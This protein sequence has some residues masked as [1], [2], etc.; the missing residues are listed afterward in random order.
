MTGTLLWVQESRPPAPSITSNEALPSVTASPSA[1]A[2]VMPVPDQLAAAQAALTRGN[3]YYDAQQWGQAIEQYKLV[4]ASGGDDPNVRTDLGNALRFNGQAQLA[5]QQYQIAQNQDPSHEQ[6][7]FNQGG[8]WTFAL[9]NPKKGVEA[10]RTYLK[11]FPNGH[12][13][14]DA[15]AFIKQ[16]ERK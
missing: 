7:L 2:P 4:I 10:W 16:H 14:K 9:H 12:S 6:S 1:S 15:R 5:L 13:A 3:S 11:R 8:L